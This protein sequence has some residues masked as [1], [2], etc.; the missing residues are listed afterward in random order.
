M[1]GTSDVFFRKTYVYI[2]RETSGEKK[3]MMKRKKKKSVAQTGVAGFEL[4][5]LACRKHVASE[6][7]S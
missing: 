2:E 7:F 6:T 4:V 3:I 1:R 5:S